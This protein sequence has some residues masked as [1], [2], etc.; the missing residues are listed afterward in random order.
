MENLIYYLVSMIAVVVI[1]VSF[2]IVCTF[3]GYGQRI[4][5]VVDKKY[6]SEST[7]Y[8]HS[9]QYVGSSSI[10][11]PEYHYSPEKFKLKLQKEEDEKIKEIWIEVPREEY[12]N[13]KIG[14]YY[15]E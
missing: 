10:S 8:T 9:T 14:D 7:Y 5:K 3:E 12:E 15:G 4:G 6:E 11:V 1:A 2:A 13:F